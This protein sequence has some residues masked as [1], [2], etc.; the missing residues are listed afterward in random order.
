MFCISDCFLLFAVCWLLIVDCIY[1]I[2]LRCWFSSPSSSS[3]GSSRPRS[4]CPVGATSF[5]WDFYNIWW[6]LRWY[7]E[8]IARILEQN[9]QQLWWCSQV[10]TWRG[11]VVSVGSATPAILMSI[12]LFVLPQVLFHRQQW[13]IIF[14]SRSIHVNTINP[15]IQPNPHANSII[16]AS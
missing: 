8:D 5:K 9:L 7:I 12:L 16:C 14:S 4:S 10:G 6:W 11:T 13:F 15:S 1:L 3:S 2:G